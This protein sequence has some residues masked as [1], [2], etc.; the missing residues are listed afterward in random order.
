MPPSSPLH[1]LYVEDDPGLASLVQRRLARE[2]HVVEVAPDGPQGLA[3]HALAPY[4]LLLLDH[5]LPGL[6]GL[7]L[8]RA[9]AA[10]GPLPPAIMLT[11]SGDEATAVAALKLGAGDYVVK[12]AAGR[13]LELLPAVI[14][15]VL[16][17]QRLAE[18]KSRAEDAL[19]ESERRF[20]EL[21]IRDELTGLFNARHFF[22]RAEAELARAAR[23][24]RP[25]ALA[26]LDVD[27][28]KHYNDTHGH[29]AG[30]QVLAALGRLI[31]AALRAADTAYRYGGEEFVLLLPETDLADAVA[32]AGRVRAAFAAT[33]LRPAADA[34]E[35]RTLS[36]GVAAF[37]PGESLSSLVERADA[38]MYRAKQLGRNR[39][40]AA[41]PPNAAPDWGLE[42]A[43][44]EAG[45]QVPVAQ[46]DVEEEGVG[47][48]GA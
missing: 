6:L 45:C 8:L 27:G 19:R 5:N 11:G 38:A 40:A 1:I 3:R 37:C 35:H 15:Q 13:Y 18:A 39:V 14:A 23:Y 2:G 33:P 46:E 16:E 17:R 7:D 26:F 9:L 29:L 21:S 41:P 32:V 30:D 28:F 34:V 31:P 12:D 25:L 4:D 20:R 10:R 47:G 24:E 42:G 44:E 36:A 43:G 22:E 48:L